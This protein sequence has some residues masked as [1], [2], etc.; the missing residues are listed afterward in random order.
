MSRSLT[1]EPSPSAIQSAMAAPTLLSS[2]SS[3][4]N[5]PCWAGA[6]AAR[7][8][9]AI[10]AAWIIHLCWRQAGPPHSRIC[11]KATGFTVAPGFCARRAE[12]AFREASLA[13]AWT[14]RLSMSHST[15]T[16]EPA[17]T[18]NPGSDTFRTSRR[19]ICRTIYTRTPARPSPKWPLLFSKRRS[20]ASQ[21]NLRMQAWP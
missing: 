9:E 10:C 12:P 19:A 8:V 3:P 18:R 14:V 5:L 17:L 11:S 13:I 21:I 4:S 7:S 20:S 1:W 2:A 6:G 16:S 15:R